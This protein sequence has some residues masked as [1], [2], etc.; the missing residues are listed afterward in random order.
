MLVLLPLSIVMTVVM[1]CS[2]YPT[3][4]YVFGKPPE[5]AARLEQ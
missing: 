3:Y 2:F 1:Y 5:P 4:T